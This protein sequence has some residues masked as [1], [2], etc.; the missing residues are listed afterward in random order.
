[1]MSFKTFS[2]RENYIIE[3]AGNAMLDVSITNADKAFKNKTKFFYYVGD[4]EKL[5]S[6]KEYSIEEKYDGVKL[7]LFR[8]GKDFD[9]KNFENNWVIAYKNRKLH[10]SE[11]KSTS[12]ANVKQ[13]GIGVSQYKIIADHLKKIHKSL[14]SIPKNT[15]F[16]VEFLMQKSTL[17]RTYENKHGVVLIGYSHNAKV[18]QEDDFRFYTKETKLNQSLNQEYAKLLKLDLPQILFEGGVGSF[19][20]LK[21][22]ALDDELKKLLRKNKT[23]IQEFY[24]YKKW[25]DLYELIK[26]IFLDVSSFYGG[27]MEGVV[28]KDIKQKTMYKFL[29]TDQHDKEF[30][31]KIKQQYKMDEDKE[32]EYYKTLDKLA[33]DIL[34]KLDLSKEHS[35]IMSDLST[36]VY[37][38]KLPRNLHTKRNDHQIKEDL[39]LKVKDAFEKMLKGWGGVVGKFRIVTKEHV[40]MIDYALKK[41]K[42][43]SV[44]LVAGSRDIMLVQENMKIFKEIFKDKPAEFFIAKT[45]NIIRLEQLTRNPIVA[46]VAGPDRKEDYQKQIEGANSD[47]VVDVYD[48]GKRD[49]ISASKAEEALMA[50]DVQ[51]LRKIVHPVALKNIDKWEK[52]YSKF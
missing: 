39:H 18:D 20:N 1:M 12:A 49:E 48:G 28:L 35:E 33:K 7:T 13:K 32:K 42:G 9:S 21:E 22:G 50:N 36:A 43:V 25:D 30:R 46:Y 29:Q 27:V 47:A 41:Y 44:M 38:K 51:S 11:F 8:N 3:A 37:K 40:N 31:Q 34:S 24:K 19:E 26:T 45:G 14:D 2:L 4:D 16:F 10:P 17:T 6:E 23:K 15:E 52:Y 5:L